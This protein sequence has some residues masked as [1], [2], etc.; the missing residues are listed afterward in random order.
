MRETRSSPS[1]IEG[2]KGGF[3]CLLRRIYYPQSLKEIS[4]PLRPSQALGP[5]TATSPANAARAGG[6]KPGLFRQPLGRLGPGF[7]PP[8]GEAAGG[9]MSASGLAKREGA[10]R[11]AK[12]RWQTE[13]D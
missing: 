7:L 5:A 6:G 2:T 4:D 3:I 8:R 11:S 9:G 10:S 1:R 13:G 12:P